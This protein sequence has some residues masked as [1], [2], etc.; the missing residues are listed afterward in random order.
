MRFVFASAAVLA[1]AL[2]VPASAGITI[3][4]PPANEKSL[5][6][7]L[8]DITVGPVAGQSQVNVDTD[9]ILDPYW[10]IE[11]TGGAIATIV[12]EMAGYAPGNSFG[13]YDL[14][15]ASNKVTIFTGA[16]DLG[17]SMWVQIFGDGKVKV[18]GSEQATFS[19]HGGNDVFGFFLHNQI[20]QT[21]YSDMLLN[22]DNLEHFVA[23]QGK[24]DEIQIG[25]LTPGKWSSEMY[26]MAFEDVAGPAS[27]RDFNDMVVMVESVEIVIPEP[28]AVLVWTFLGA[29]GACVLRRRRKSQSS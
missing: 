23:F 1:I 20:G 8:D 13:I 19:L 10:S 29:V 12:I 9:Q 26:A 25:D 22:D 17:D 28:A 3:G 21:F 18:N 5:Q 4:D 7:I 16:N 11:G 14:G 6:Q 24:G 15:N 2:A 27:D